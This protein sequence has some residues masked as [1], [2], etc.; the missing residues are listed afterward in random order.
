MS[1]LQSNFLLSVAHDVRA[2]VERYRR[3]SIEAHRSFIRIGKRLLEARKEA[4]RGQWGPFLEACGLAERSARNMMTVA[5]GAWTAK[6]MTRAGGVRVALDFEALAPSIRGAD[7]D[8]PRGEL[9]IRKGPESFLAFCE[10]MNEE[11][12]DLLRRIAA[13]HKAPRRENGHVAGND[14]PESAGPDGETARIPDD[15][16]ERRAAVRAEQEA[17]RE[18]IAREVEATAE[19]VRRELERE[20]FRPA[21][22]PAFP[23]PSVPYHDTEVWPGERAADRLRRLRAERRAAGRCADCA[24]WSG[25]AYRCDGCARKRATL[26]DRAASRRRIGRALEGQIRKAAARGK[27]VRLSAD[28]VRKLVDVESRAVFEAKARRILGR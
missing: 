16:D 19:S 20:R 1:L 17:D 7:E 12:A 27:G 13:E 15:L 5:R 10:S 6:A 26:N 8:L 11:P 2:D 23:D 14:G 24:A 28:D 25:D 9:A 18:R 4:K 3:S 21:S 22:A